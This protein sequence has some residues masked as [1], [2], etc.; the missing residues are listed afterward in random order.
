M[1]KYKHIFYVAV[2]AA[3]LAACS[4]DIDPTGEGRLPDGKYPLELTASMQ[5]MTTRAEGEKTTWVENDVIGVRIGDES[6][7]G[8]YIIKDTEGTIVEAETPLYWNSLDYTVVTAWYPYEPT[9]VNIADQ[10]SEDF[11]PVDFLLASESASIRNSVNLRF[12]HRMARIWYGLYNE[13]GMSESDWQNVKVKFY[14]YTSVASDA[15]GKLTGSAEGWITPGNDG[16]WYLPQNMT[17]KELI[18]VT[19]TID[20]Q[21]KTFVYSPDDTEEGDIVPGMFYSYTITV[22]RDRIEVQAVSGAEWTDGG[23]QNVNSDF[24]PVGDKPMADV[25]AGDFYFS[26]GTFAD[27]D[28]ELTERQ[29]N[30]CVGIVFYKGQHDNDGSD[31]S[32]SGIGQQK[33][34]GYV[35]ALTD[36]HN[37]SSDQLCWEKGPANEDNIRVDVSSSSTDWN[38]YYNL[39]KIHEF[40]TSKSSDGWEMKHFPAALACETYGNR[41]LDRDGNSTTAYEWQKQFIAPENTSGWFHPSCGQLIYLKESSEI[42]TPQIQKVADKTSNMEAHD[43]MKWFNGSIYYWSSTESSSLSDYAWATP[44]FNNISR[45]G[46]KNTNNY[47]RAILAF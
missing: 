6:V 15:E 3:T 46:P 8:K 22:K 41:T 25:Q 21:A 31:Y 45:S 43:Y 42:I 14:G 39:Q 2:A 18:R 10:S 12:T 23:S 16:T 47:V 26:D 34:N 40:V 36:V 28:A 30:Y 5:G 32:D 13:A 7:T 4:N 38:G 33:C 37:G 1:K 44:F 19:A 35:V 24:I 29:A 9:T 27:K 20:G 17:G 11:T